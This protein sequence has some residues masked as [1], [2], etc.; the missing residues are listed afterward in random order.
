MLWIFVRRYADGLKEI[1]L[2]FWC[3]VNTDELHDEGGSLMSYIFMDLFLDR[4]ELKRAFEKAAANDRQ[5]LIHF[6]TSSNDFASVCD[7]HTAEAN[8]DNLKGVI[9]QNYSDYENL[10]VINVYDTSKDFDNAVMAQQPDIIEKE[11]AALKHESAMSARPWWKVL[12]N[13]N[14]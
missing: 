3:Y 11:M 9:R 5:Y 2:C 12:F 1:L 14:P 6:G 10:R 7:E 4:D 13:I 8:D